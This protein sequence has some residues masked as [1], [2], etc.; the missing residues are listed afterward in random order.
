MVFDENLL[1]LV[2][3]DCVD[4]MMVRLFLE[5]KFFGPGICT[6]VVG[7]TKQLVLFKWLYFKHHLR[8]DTK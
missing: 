3:C 6:T 2:D 1:L 7:L 5:A 4:G 8:V